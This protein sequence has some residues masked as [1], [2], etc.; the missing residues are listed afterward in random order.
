MEKLMVISADSHVVEP[1]DL[2][3][4]SLGCKY[5]DEVPRWLDS[6]KGRR[7]MFFFGGFDYLDYGPVIYGGDDDPQLREKLKVAGYDPA[8]RIA[9]LDEDG[10]YSE[11]VNATSTLFVLRARN[12]NMA[13]ECCEVFN[14]WLADYCSYAPKRLYGTAM[15][16][17]EDVNWAVKELE[18]GAKRGLRSVLINCDT[19]PEWEPYQDKK[20]DPFWARAQELDMPV[21]L[22]IISG[23]VAD[24][25]TLYGEQRKAILRNSLGL[26]AEGPIVLG[27]EFIFGGIFDR[28]PR[29]KV[30]CSEFEVSWVPYWFF[31][32]KQMQEK[33]GPVM[34]I[35]KI[36]RRV[37]EY[38][39]E[40]VS[41][42]VIEDEYISQ[43]LEVIDPAT[44]MW[45]SDFPHVAS[46]YPHTHQVIERI[47]G[48]LEPEVREGITWK[49]AARFYNLEAPPLM[50]GL[51]VAKS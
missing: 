50:S 14:D 36:K 20:Y 40:Q 22:H 34:N 46:T 8:A 5:G 3:T 31:R 29:L 7:G 27:N 39:R 15:I 25:F 28:F 45:G 1:P 10:V 35:P 48:P 6:Y 19:R 42:G 30:V 44:V 9:C 41:H 23:N 11:I 32:M 12:D 51:N 18:R 24:P 37:E 4:K 13:R 33:L 49:N 2:F 47:F 26:F 17:M 43:A 21:T 16:H 38:L